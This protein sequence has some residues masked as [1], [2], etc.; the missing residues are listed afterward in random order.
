MSDLDFL[1]FLFAK[2]SK[3]SKKGYIP[4]YKKFR[5]LHTFYALKWYY[6]RNGFDIFAP[7]GRMDRPSAGLAG[8]M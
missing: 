3:K 6:F 7:S 2:K 1:N 5:T 8:V 4:I